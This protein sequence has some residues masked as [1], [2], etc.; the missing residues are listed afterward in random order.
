M[1]ESALHYIWKNR[2]YDALTLDGEPLAVLDTG[3]HNIG[4]GPDFLVAK[5]QLGEIVWA[6]A[7]ELH[8]RSSDWYRHH[9]EQDPRYSSVVLHVVLSP[10]RPVVDSTGRVVPTACLTVEERVVERIRQLEESNQ[11]LRCMPELS[12]V[13]PEELT[14]QV[15]P[16]LYERMHQKLIKLSD[17]GEQQYTNTFFYRSLMRYLGAHQNND[18]MEQVAR[19]LPYLYLKKHASDLTALE[20]MLLGQAGLISDAPRDDYEQHLAEWYTFYREKFGLHP[21]SPGVFKKL[22]VRPP[23]YPARMLAIAAQILH[24]EDDLRAAMAAGD[25]RQ[26]TELLRVAPSS[27]WETHIDFGQSSKRRMGAPGR[28]TL[29][30][31]MINAIIPTA[32]LYAETIGDERMAEAAIAH[33]SMLEAEQNRVTRLFEQNGITATSAA[34]SQAMLQLYE[35]YCTPYRCLSCPMAPAIFHHLHTHDL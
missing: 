16:L 28:S 24:R 9:H 35:Q 31:L 10:D 1:R 27:Y 25:Y 29:L 18:A 7:V 12:Y 34:D 14:T 22:R 6:G 4:D 32:Y 15:A 3:Q 23:S 13:R 20:A 8:L 33:L 26:A 30:T 19:S 17:E 11:S 21:L 5:V 2:L